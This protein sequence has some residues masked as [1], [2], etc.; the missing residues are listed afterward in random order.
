MLRKSIESE[1]PL[2]ENLRLAICSSKSA[3]ALPVRPKRG[4]YAAPRI[5]VSID[6]APLLARRFVG[7]VERIFTQRRQ[8]FARL[9]RFQNGLLGLELFRRIR[10]RLDG[11]ANAPF[12]LVDL[13]HARVHFLADLEDVFD[14]VGALFASHSEM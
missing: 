7:G 9:E 10:G 6:Y 8:V 1:N 2:S 3:S 14:L 13:D 4:A 5:C 12:A 11:Q